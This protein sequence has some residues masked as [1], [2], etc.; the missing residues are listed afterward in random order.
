MKRIVP[1]FTWI[2]VASRVHARVFEPMR[3]DGGLQLV[4]EFECPQGRQLAGD[5]EV[6]RPGRM[7][8]SGGRPHPTSHHQDG[9]EHLAETFAQRIAHALRKARTDGRFKRLVLVA[10]PHFLG[11][12]R[13]AL[14]PTTA[15]LSAGSI[16]K[17]L[18]SA[19]S[20]E[21][22]RQLQLMQAF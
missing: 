15:K 17:G 21:I 22:A 5:I 7:R 12:L 3:S 4:D 10:D 19:P 9:T 6:D 8:G 2:V 11:L 1:A 16:S 14:D 20:E 18:D 13:G